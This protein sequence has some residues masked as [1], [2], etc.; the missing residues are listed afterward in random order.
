MNY[1]SELYNI[2]HSKCP[3]NVITWK[4]FE[5]YCC[6]KLNFIHWNYIDPIIKDTFIYNKDMGIDGLSTDCKTS[7]QCKWRND[8]T[9]NFTE[10]STFNTY[11]QLLK[12]ENKIL[13]HNT[14]C[15]ISNNLKTIINQLNIELKEFNDNFKDEVLEL[16]KDYKPVENVVLM[17]YTL[18]SYQQDVIDLIK[19]N[20][21]EYIISIPCGTGKTIIYC[22]MCKYYNDKSVVIFVPTRYLLEQTYNVLSRFVGVS[23]HR[24]PKKKIIR[25]GTGY[26]DKVKEGK[27]NIYICVY[28]SWKVIEKFKIDVCIIDE[29]HHFDKYREDE[30]EESDDESSEDDD[31]GTER[32]ESEDEGTESDDESDEEIYKNIEKLSNMSE[33]G[34]ES[35]EQ[36]ETEEEKSKNNNYLSSIHSLK[37]NKKIKFSATFKDVSKCDYVYS[38]DK[39]IT[40]KYLTDY[41]III[42]TLNIKDDIQ[43]G[44][45][46]LLLQQPE[47]VYVLAYC[48]SIN[49]A[50][51]FSKLL[52]KHKITSVCLTNKTSL[53]QREKYIR[54]FEK[55][56]IRVIVSVYV[57]GEGVDI[58]IASCCMF[59]EPRR[60][61]TNVIQC[62]GRVLRL[63]PNKNVANI[64]LPT[65]NELDELNNFMK[66]I[67]DSDSRIN[68]LI[69]RRFMG[70]ITF[71]KIVFENEFDE[72]EIDTLNIYNRIG[73]FIEGYRFQKIKLLIKYKTELEEKGKKIIRTT[74][75]KLNNINELEIIKNDTKDWEIGNWYHSL[76]NYYKSNKL[77]KDELKLCNEYKLFINYKPKEN[78]YINKLS[79]INRVELFFKYK[80][81]KLQLPNSRYEIILK[82]DNSIWKI[83]RFFEQLKMKYINNILDANIKKLCDDN[84][85]YEEITYKPKLKTYITTLSYVD[86]IKLLIKYKNELKL[87]NIPNSYK[88]ILKEDN[89]IWQIGQFLFDLKRRGFDKLNDDI[90][91]LCIDNKLVE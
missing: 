30:D 60:Q 74:K 89:S 39:A 42:P 46:K 79:Y 31:E 12:I 90:K 66:I 70:R 22:E 5:L 21:D 27:N 86:K 20:K 50:N 49:S 67:A 91:K 36:S 35:D 88:I 40:D 38:L 28:N 9:I 47:L 80:K 53:K 19:D 15:K 72:V 8:N 2:Y 6:Y 56:E 34:T 69:K 78:I 59:V 14:S 44:L 71:A 81:N 43:I 82:E 77:T 57:L 41:N 1:I 4:L 11:S 26:N 85:L 16:I 13:S 45:C 62:I 61:K 37:F 73:E 58:P 17:N 55:G 68:N 54:Q 10:L 29:A 51:D 18:R 64:I 75:I 24:E 7:L 63:H 3:D 32:E 25:V 76:T 87:K 48:N 65:T 83:G 33:E 84:K 52:I 23:E